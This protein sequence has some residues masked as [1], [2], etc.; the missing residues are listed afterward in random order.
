[1]AD[2]TETLSSTAGGATVPGFQLT[3]V[4]VDG[5]VWRGEAGRCA[6]G[7]HALNDLQLD[8]GAVSRFHCEVV[9]GDDGARLRDLGSKNG[10]VVDGV[11]VVEVFLRSGSLIMVGRSALRFELLEERHP[12]RLSAHTRF[13][14]LLGESVA[15][16]A[17]FALLERAADSDATLLLEGETG[18]GKGAAAE[19]VHRAGARR[20]KPFVV[21]DCGALPG[22]LL[23]SELFGHERGAFTGADSRRAGAFE[24]ADGG[25]VF[26]DE[27]GDLP[28]ELQPKLLRA[29]ENREVRRLGQNSYQK[30]D[31]RLIAATH[32]D[33][34]A[35]VNTGGFRADLY[36]RLAVLRVVLPALRERREDL[37]GLARA[38]LDGLGADAAALAALE[39][40]AL[41]ARLAGAAW[42][43]N[44]REL[45]N[46]LER[47]LVMRA[48]LPLAEVAPAAP[49]PYSD[50]R[51]RALDAFERAYL[52][53]LLVRHHGKVAD[54]AREA[55]IARV[56]FYR[57]LRRH[58]IKP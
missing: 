21:V 50:A 38:L 55:G 47:C 39:L 26:L 8:D 41:T 56:Y 9:V 49:L 12:L 4:D 29:L 31:V 25:T 57:L 18:T 30:V 53:D 7:S 40:P 32:R 2:E 5:R 42:P 6:I 48:P 10:T 1:M 14:G 15:M 36:F 3:V 37:P 54:A 24:E 46:Y 16:R 34:R 11:R 51:Q 44:V 58:G 52:G 43:G 27:V 17:A 23:E 28:A 19:A 20:R 33:L 45:R 22:N 35:A 13:G